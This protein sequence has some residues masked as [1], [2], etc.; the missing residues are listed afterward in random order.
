VADSHRKR[1]RH[2]CMSCK[3]AGHLRRGLQSAF[4]LSSRPGSSS[5]STAEGRARPVR[6]RDFVGDAFAGLGQ[7]GGQPVPPAIVG[8]DGGGIKQAVGGQLRN[9]RRGRVSDQNPKLGGAP[10]PRC[11]VGAQTGA[12]YRLRTKSAG[13]IES[14]ARLTRRS[15][16]AGNRPQ[17]TL[18]PARRIRS[19]ASGPDSTLP[20]FTESIS[21][22]LFFCFFL[23][24]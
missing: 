12:A 18:E 4:R 22:R 11:P 17:P 16:V 3:N 6:A 9:Q 1:R 10:A 14:G 15:C 7:P 20:L 5:S 21:Q 23:F 2:G 13:G 24:G 19:V 8:V